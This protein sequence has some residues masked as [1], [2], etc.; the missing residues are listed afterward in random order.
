M[1]EVHLG[2]VST[3]VSA[4]ENLPASG[5]AARQIIAIL[6][7]VF[8]AGKDSIKPLAHQRRLLAGSGNQW[9]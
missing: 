3:F 6:P 1:P 2:F 4:M 5:C 8:A 7:P 9:G